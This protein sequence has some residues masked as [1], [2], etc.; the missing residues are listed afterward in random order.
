MT[1]VNAALETLIAAQR[2]IS[3]DALARAR[4][5]QAETG[6]RLDS[7]L[8][9]LG[10]IPERDLADAL[11]RA[12]EL[13]VI[14]ADAFPAAPVAGD[15][16]AP[17]FLRDVRAVPLAEDD[18]QAEVAVVNPLDAFSLRALSHAIGKPVVARVAKAGDLEAALDRL[19]PAEALARSGDDSADEADVERLRDMA[20]DAPVVRAVNTLIA[21]AAEA[22]A[23]DIHIEPTEDALQVRFRIDGALRDEPALPVQIKAAFVSRI[24][25]MAGLNIAER[26]LPQDGRIRQSVRGN[27]IDLR[28]ATAPTIHGESVVM[29][30][31]DRS[32]LALDF[33][34]LGFSPGN[35]GALPSRPAP[36]ARH[37]PGHRPDRQRQD[38]HPLRRP[39]GTERPRPQ[40]PDHRGPDRIPADRDQPDPDQSADR[41]DLRRRPALLPAPGPGRDDGRR[42]PRSGN[43]PGG[44]AGRAHR[45]RH[46]VHPAHQQRRRR[47]DPADG[48]GRRAVPDHL[49]AQRS[50]G[51]TP[52]APPLPG[53]PRAQAGDAPRC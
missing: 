39:V 12:A 23:S 21:R 22:G 37:R 1:V 51:P 49:D 3:A 53:L 4:L 38:H 47:R 42:D 43:R 29:R 11:A 28:I 20:S 13:Q 8:T 10:L 2:L 34:V 24:K 19:Y 40:D 46:P 15:R 36:A 35:A 5:V 18:G 17:R 45:P 50:A 41:P 14:E 6:E 26:R 44:G 30:L 31:L 25:V 7:V 16:L 32:N 52:G 48:H 27:E 33:A 9:R